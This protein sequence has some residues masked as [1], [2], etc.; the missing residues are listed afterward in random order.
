MAPLTQQ[1]FSSRC[2][3]LA[4][5]VVSIAVAT[6]ANARPGHATGDKELGEYLSSQCTTCHQRS[7]KGDA[8]PS[9]IGWD[10]GSFIAIMNAY[11]KKERD[12]KVM[13]TIA[14]SLSAEDIAALAAYFGSLK[15]KP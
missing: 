12:N 2:R 13:Q 7:G 15:P 11:K 1:R 5:S 10:T 6:F 4:L 3:L 8:I 14:S 9:I